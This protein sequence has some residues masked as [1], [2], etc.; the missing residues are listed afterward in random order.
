MKNTYLKVLVL[1]SLGFKEPLLII[2][3]TYLFLAYQTLRKCVILYNLN[4]FRVWQLK[5]IQYL[6]MTF[7][8]NRFPEIACFRFLRIL[9][10]IPPQD[11]SN[12]RR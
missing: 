8:M 3:S 6:M 12:L 9:L 7:L 5:I 4:Y 11:P 1:L 2:L 10:S